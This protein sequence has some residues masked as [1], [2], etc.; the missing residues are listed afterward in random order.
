MFVT[1]FMDVFTSSKQ[2]SSRI[3]TSKLPIPFEGDPDH[4]WYWF[5]LNSGLGEIF[6]VRPWWPESGASGSGDRRDL[7]LLGDGGVTRRSGPVFAATNTRT[8]RSGA[9]G[10]P[11]LT[12]KGHPR[13]K[14]SPE[15]VDPDEG[16]SFRRWGP[17]SDV[18][19]CGRQGPQK[20][21]TRVRTR[22]GFVGFYPWRRVWKLFYFKVFKKKKDF[23]R[24]WQKH[25]KS[26]WEYC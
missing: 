16:V 10:Y 24:T 20:I 9:G 7:P 4:W 25:N 14:W 13:R 19:S 22:V 17:P 21:L 3:V 6:G 2:R 12:P 1:S 11:S 5:P 15:G 26:T 23:I 18:V 8:N